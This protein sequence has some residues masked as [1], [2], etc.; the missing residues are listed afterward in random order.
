M[1][2]R[3]MCTASSTTCLPACH[4]S[5]RCWHWSTPWSWTHSSQG[6]ASVL[7]GLPLHQALPMSRY[8][9]VTASVTAT[10]TVTAAIIVTE[11]VTP[12]VT[13]KRQPSL[14]LLLQ[15]SPSKKLSQLPLSL[16]LQHHCHSNFHG[17]CS[18]IN[19]TVR[20]CHCNCFC[21]PLQ[22]LLHVTAYVE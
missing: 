9:T 20:T 14:P 17:D 12:M 19:V 21:M 8:R 1:P 6:P 22:L 4:W 7:V 5:S 11:I 2:R 3:G 18:S 16:P 15:M 13:V 10:V